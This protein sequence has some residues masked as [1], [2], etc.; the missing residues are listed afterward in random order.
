MFG[1]TANVGGIAGVRVPAKYD[2]FDGLPAKASDA[3]TVPGADTD[4]M[5][6]LDVDIS[7]PT[8]PAPPGGYPLVVFMHGCCAGDKFAWQSRRLR[9]RASAG[10]TTTHGSRH[11]VTWW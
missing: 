10:T 8:L 4:G 6:T 2:G 7:K 9:Q 1:R 11:A 3:T 5:I